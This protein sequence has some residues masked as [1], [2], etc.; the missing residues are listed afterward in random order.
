MQMDYHPFSRIVQRKS[1]LNMK[2]SLFI[3]LLLLAFTNAFATP[4]INVSTAYYP[5]S[6]ITEDQLRDQ[7]N[8]LGPTMNG[9]HYDSTT[10]WY[11]S[12]HYQYRYDTPSQNP[13]YLTSIDV[14]V[15]IHS[16]Y[17]Q[18]M[19]MNQ[20]NASL[21]NKWNTYL[22]NLTIHE[23]G[24]VENG[25][26]AAYDMEKALYGIKPQS[27]CSLLINTAIPNATQNVLAKHNNWDTQYDLET[28]HGKTQG[29]VFP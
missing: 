28:A 18:W 4:M 24:H 3:I 17:P 13:C 7:M 16:T 8:T 5:I 9:Q 10:T 14:S 26:E 11:V 15:D 12:W 29:A 2:Q 23:Q 1:Y 22:N 6:G 25:K 21:Q 19:N 20:G 27:S